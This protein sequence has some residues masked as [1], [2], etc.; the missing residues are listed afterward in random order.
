M[1]FK[2][3]PLQHRPPRPWPL[4]LPRGSDPFWL[5]ALQE[6][7]AEELITRDDFLVLADPMPRPSSG[8]IYSG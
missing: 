4:P 7:L 1:G 6:M 2:P 8:R 3:A 5:A